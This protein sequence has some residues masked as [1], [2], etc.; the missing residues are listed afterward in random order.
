MLGVIYVLI[1]QALGL[2]IG[3]AFYFVLCPLVSIAA[4]APVSINGLGVREA[5]LAAL[6]PLIGIGAAR[7]VA[8]GLAWTAMVT[9]A[10]LLGGLALLCLDAPFPGNGETG[11]TVEAQRAAKGMSEA[12]VRK[13]LKRNPDAATL[14]GRLRLCGEKVPL[15][16]TM[17]ALPLLFMGLCQR[18]FTDN[19]GMYAEIGREMLVSGNWLTPHVNGSV[20]LNKPPLLFWLTALELRVGGFNELPRLISGL[21]TLATMLLISGIGRQLWP[22]RPASG[23]W[24]AA[25]Y[26]SSALHSGRSAYPP[27]GFTA[28][29]FH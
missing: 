8:F 25:A 10:D 29:V 2:G 1:G 19:E 20:Y 24:A 6:F 16:L 12:G 21:A 14:S 9:L 22:Q 17:I 11:L 28:D 18:G 15:L 3:V 4:M 5:T 23:A 13:T 7:A 26:L 27:A